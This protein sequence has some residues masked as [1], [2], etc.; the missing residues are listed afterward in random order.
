[1]GIAIV[2]T[3]LCALTLI[4]GEWIELIFGVDPD[5]NSGLLEWTIVSCSAATAIGSAY[6]ARMGSRRF[7]E[8]LT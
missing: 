1:M 8:R 4:S 5:S 2:A 6:A 7:P 3:G